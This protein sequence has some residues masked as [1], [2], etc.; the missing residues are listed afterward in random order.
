MACTRWRLLPILLAAALLQLAPVAFA[1][2]PYPPATA[3][4]SATVS[5]S[6]VEAGGCVTFR[7]TGFAPGTAVLIRDT[8]AGAAR[9]RVVGTVRADKSGDFSTRVCFGASARRGRHTVSGTGTGAG[10]GSLTVSADVWVTGVSQLPSSAGGAIPFTG[11]AGPGLALAGIALLAGGSALLL[12][13]D[14][15]RRRRRH[16]VRPGV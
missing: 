10:G 9:G 16:P 1:A 8:P 2:G 13:T 14:R 4:G 12:A 6:R 15:R 7:G 3:E 11:F 5:Q